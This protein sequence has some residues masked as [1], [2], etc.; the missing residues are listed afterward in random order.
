MLHSAPFNL[1]QSK[2]VTFRAPCD[3]GLL[4][5]VRVE[6]FMPHKPHRET[7]IERI[8]REVIGRKMPLAVRRVLLRKRKPKRHR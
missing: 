4:S 2:D 5:V 1:E 7:P 6:G 3:E 8:Y